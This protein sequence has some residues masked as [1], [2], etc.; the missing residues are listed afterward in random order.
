M[1]PS[2]PPPHPPPS[3]VSYVLRFLGSEAKGVAAEA[4]VLT[5]D[6][7]TS[8][9]TT[10]YSLASASS[11]TWTSTTSNSDSAIPSSNG[12]GSDT[13]N[14]NDKGNGVMIRRPPLISYPQTP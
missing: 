5:I 3:A 7:Y 12:V 14:D 8:A 9:L 10:S 6:S 11:K 4:T 2:D 13:K 1:L